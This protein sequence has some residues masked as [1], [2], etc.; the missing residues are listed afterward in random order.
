MS[1]VA[2]GTKCNL[3]TGYTDGED[4]EVSFGKKRWLAQT[5]TLPDTYVVWRCRLKSWTNTG[6]EFYGYALK[7]TDGLGKPIGADLAATTLSPMGEAFGQPPKWRRFDFGSFPNLPAGVYALVARVPTSAVTWGHKLRCDSSA[8]GYALGKAWESDDEGATWTEIPGTDFMFEV[9]GWLPPPVS[10]P[11]PVISNWAPLDLSQPEVPEC[12]TITVTTDIPVHLFMRWTDIEPLTHATEL[13]RRGISLPY[14]TRWCFVAW[15]EVEQEETGDTYTHTFILCDWEVCETRWFYF[16]GTKQAE[17]SPSASP[18]FYY[19]REGVPMYVISLGKLG[20]VEILHGHVKLSEGAG[21]S[22]TRDDPNNALQIAATVTPYEGFGDHW[23]KYDPTGEL[24]TT[25]GWGFDDVHFATKTTG[26]DLRLFTASM[27]AWGLN[28][29]RSCEHILTRGPDGAGNP[30]VYAA[31]VATTADIRGNMNQQCI[32]WRTAPNGAVSCF[33]GDGV[34][35]TKTDFAWGNW[36]PPWLKWIRKV[37]SIE[38]YANG[39]LVATHNTNLPTQTNSCFFALQAYGT[40]NYVRTI[41]M[42]KPHYRM[43]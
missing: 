7:A 6:G 2:G 14:A 15:N 23:V 11:E 19:H 3:I 21:I 34:N 29:P 18:I 25:I 8:A 36:P 9:W 28:E 13:V 40:T 38:F 35:F 30:W 20:E 31:I 5:F 16:V 10:D 39:T 33:N 22:I 43:D 1:V 26:A 37:G 42:T 24:A 12:H 27:R 4:G 41:Y 17:E 32:G